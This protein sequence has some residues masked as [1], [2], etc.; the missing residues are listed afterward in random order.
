MFLYNKRRVS[1]LLDTVPILQSIKS[2]KKVEHFNCPYDKLIVCSY[3]LPRQQFIDLIRPARFETD[4]DESFY[5]YKLVY[6][7]FSVY[8][9]Q[10]NPLAPK[11]SI[12]LNPWKHQLSPDDLLALVDFIIGSHLD[13]HV[14]HNDDKLD[15]IQFLTPKEFAKRIYVGYQKMPTRNYDDLDKTFMYGNKKGQQVIIYDKAEEQGLDGEIWTRLEKSRKRRDKRS[16]PT[17][18]QF[19]LEQRC[20]ALKNVVIVD[21]DKFSGRDK[22]MRRIN[23][24]GTFQEAYM[25]LTEEEK[26]KIKRH[27]A[28]KS[29][30][31]DVVAMFK[32]ELDKWLSLSPNLHFMCKVFPVFKASWGGR[33]ELQYRVVRLKPIHLNYT[34]ALSAYIGDNNRFS[35][36]NDYL[37]EISL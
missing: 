9:M 1:E 10:M 13:T 2:A 12:M 33:D 14:A 30:L 5:R 37:A 28:F 29:P 27:E 25:S 20:D 4:D 34:E 22:I 8:W 18:M 19:L 21:I 11:T 17:L 16:R 3:K 36:R 6:D 23:K 7:L 26:R 35:L 15:W 31:F 24:Y 32:S